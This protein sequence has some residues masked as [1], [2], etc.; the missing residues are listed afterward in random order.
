VVL[1]AAA[2]AILLA[3]SV[4]HLDLW[5]LECALPHDLA[6]PELITAVD[7]VHLRGRRQEYKQKGCI[8]ITPQIARS[9]L[10]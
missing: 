3:A 1:G 5:V 4:P 6:G 7:D 8:S 9:R 10:R 2:A